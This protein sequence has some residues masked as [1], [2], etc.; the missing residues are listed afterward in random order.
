MLSPELLMH[1]TS[2]R[3]VLPLT[4]MSGTRGQQAAFMNFPSGGGP[5]GNALL[6]GWQVDAIFVVQ[7]G[8]P[9]TVSQQQGL[10]STGTGNRPNRIASGTLD[11]PT[12]DHWFDL[13]AFWPTSDN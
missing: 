4:L 12:P 6:G 3:I 10:L 2:T 5:V 11:H 8:L 1:G 9:F 7:S 13:T